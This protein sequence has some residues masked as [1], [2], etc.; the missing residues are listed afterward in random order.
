MPSS[1]YSGGARAS[2]SESAIM[3]ERVHQAQ[4][5]LTRQR[6]R[7]LAIDYPSTSSGSQFSRASGASRASRQSHAPSG[8]S[9]AGGSYHSLR[10]RDIDPSDSCSNVGSVQSQSMVSTHS[11]VSNLS[12]ASTSTVR[13]EDSLSQVGLGGGIGNSK[14]RGHGAPTPNGNGNGNGHR[15]R[16]GRDLSG[17]ELALLHAQGGAHA[18]TVVSFAGSQASRNQGPQ[19]LPYAASNAGSNVSTD[20]TLVIDMRDPNRRPPP[21]NSQG[22]GNNGGRRVD[23]SDPA[24]IVVTE[25][26]IARGREMWPRLD[27][28]SIKARMKVTLIREEVQRR[29]REAGIGMRR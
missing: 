8:P 24:N 3:M 21:S 23:P 16:E 14:T 19:L 20:S 9:Q 1:Y 5:D 26:D 12:R 17:R 18:P 13:P 27:R 10:E 6:Q 25:A 15:A 7:Q 11:R 2:D 29:A 28:E 4:R 22:P